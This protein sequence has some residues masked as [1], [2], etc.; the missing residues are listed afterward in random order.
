M[1][2]ELLTALKARFENNMAR[3]PG[4]VWVT[5]LKQNEQDYISLTDIAKKFGDDV[6]R[7]KGAQ[8]YTNA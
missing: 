7:K 3:H 2:N 5:V 4:L 8:V 6:L 1:N